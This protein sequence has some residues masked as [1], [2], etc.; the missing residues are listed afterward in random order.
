[1]FFCNILLPL[2]RFIKPCTITFLMEERDNLEKAIQGLES[3]RD[4][5][6]DA[7]VDAAV[8]VLRQ[9]LAELESSAPDRIEDQAAER[10]AERRV[11]TVL[12][13]DVTGSTALAESMDPETWTGIMNAAF[14][15]LIEPVERYGGTV[16]RLMGDAI[17]AF[18]GAPTAHEDDPQRAVLAGLAIVENILPYRKKLR[19]EKGLDFN[20]R[21]GINTGLAV[22]GDVGSETAGEYT[23]MGD[24]VNLA[25]RMEQTAAPGTVQITQDTYALIAPLFEFEELG[26]IPVKGKAEPVLAFRVLS[27]KSEPGS[28]RG[29]TEQGISSPFVGRQSELE[30][31]KIALEQLAAGQGGILA[32]L[33]EAGIGK[34]RLIT[35]LRASTQDITAQSNLLEQS[36]KSI[37]WLEGQPLSYSQTISYWP[38]QQI[39]RQYAGINDDD[40]EITALSKLEGKILGL[41]PGETAQ[42]LPYLASILALELGG[43]YFE[44]VKYLDGEALG[45]QIY[46]A[47]WR[48]FHRLAER[49]PLVL[50]FDDLHWM[51][52]S[53]AGLLDHLL[54]L[55]E[56][57]PLLFCGLSRPDQAAPAAKLLEAAEDRFADRLT[58]IEL[59]PLTIDDSH[60]LVQNLL[61]IDGLPDKSRAMILEKADGNPFYLEEIVRELIDEGA[62]VRDSSTGHWQAT[63]RITNVHVPDT[64]Q[65]LLIARIDRLDENLK[66]VV[67]R[68]AV[69]GRAFLY[70][71][72]SAVVG[73]ERPLE[74]E[75]IQLQ[76]AEL[77]QELQPL[78]ELEYIFKHALAQEA[79]YEGILIEERRAVHA[80]VG[81]AIERLMANR[82]EEFY[83]LLAYHY[84]AAEQWEQAQEYLFKAGDQAGRMAAD[85]EA[86]ALYHQAMEAYNLV[87]GDEWEP[88]EKARLE[89]K[90][91]EAFYR[92]G[93]YGQARA[94]LERSL[95]LLG[96]NLPDSKWGVRLSIASALLRQAGHRFFPSWFVRP[97]SDSPNEI[98]EELYKSADALGW[99]EGV[100]D[101]E[102]LLLLSVRVLNASEKWG[103]AFGSSYLASTLAVAFDLLGWQ[104]LAE[105]YYQLARKYSQYTDPVRLGFQL[106]WSRAL[107]YN[108]NADFTKSLEHARRGVEFSQ[109]TGDVRSW[110]AVMDLSTWSHLTE[111]R[112]A[113]AIATSQEMIEVAEEGS[114]L[115][116][117]CWGLMGR[118]V[119]MKR[120]GKIDEAISYLERAIE[121]AEEVP[122]Y[123]TQVAASGWLGR[124]YVA[125]GNSKQALTKLEASQQ[126]LS[127][128]SIVMEIAILGDGLSEAYLAQAEL[129]TGKER[130]AWLQKAKRSCQESLQAARRYRPPMLD[131]Q[132][133]RGRYEWLIGN[134]SVAINWW[135]KALQEAEHNRDPYG[136]GLVH[137]EIGSRMGHRDQLEQAIPL[138]E[139]VGAEFELAQAKEAL[140]KIGES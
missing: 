121:V 137:L 105:P 19:V 91:G 110:G 106:E 101:V 87:R 131:A 18:F 14:E 67:R 16:A 96:E 28:L 114:D 26:G 62:L 13:C 86:L 5:L 124:C 32:V 117:L 70:R 140:T 25:A 90:I 100:A 123:H 58:V 1:L 40:D 119:T 111:G 130:Q 122:D 75:L 7:A 27:Q 41:F 92:L 50:L 63:K 94:Y 9:R 93:N 85:A 60:H 15:H 82:L 2:N 103:N 98:A 47:S 8:D 109:S 38:F 95:A 46:R 112:M 79:A 81:S 120:L 102:R 53:S 43:E 133:L 10:S 69:I 71:I 76:T 129:S 56:R 22:V 3:Q 59:S 44:R 52:A 72:L 115:Q 128:Q 73:D 33:G 35:E 12:F 39:M 65:G 116:V 127:N 61:E 6:G 17:L 132:L 21:V 83:G 64:I 34:S 4:S 113:E 23:A 20:V 29:L 84:S 125:I 37:S 66:Y 31:A 104:S 11:V 89:R 74:H 51:D 138:L 80:R 118:G 136:E 134:S 108:I 77:I 78:P 57:V 42:I 36:P 48:F 88:L 30:S 49:S 135:D 126:V 55:M 45:S 68:A 139:K 54:P 99:I 107:H 97:M 24:A